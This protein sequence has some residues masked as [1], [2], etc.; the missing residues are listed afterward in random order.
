MAEKIL[1]REY[2]IPLRKEFM[3]VPRYRKSKKSI[4]AIKEFISK[5]MKVEEVKIGSY[6]NELVWSRGPKNPIP[7]VKV[8][9]RKIDDYAQVELI[10]NKFAETKEEKEEKESKKKKKEDK[11]ETKEEKSK[12]MTQKEEDKLLKEDK[13]KEVLEKESGVVGIKEKE[14]KQRTKQQEEKIRSEKI[15]SQTQKPHKSLKK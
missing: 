4:K 5:H 2:V 7:R 15:I 3:K 10:D 8:K 9:T 6:L 14:Q 11:K 13:A 1:E 12:E